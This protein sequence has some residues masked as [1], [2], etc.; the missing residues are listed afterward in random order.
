MG[1]A[2]ATTTDVA[3]GAGDT[4]GAD[5]HPAA[6]TAAATGSQEAEALF[7]RPSLR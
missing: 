2:G 4:G 5:V 1:A 3:D 7:K 6:S